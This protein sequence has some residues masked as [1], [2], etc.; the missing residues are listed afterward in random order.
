VIRYQ[1]DMQEHWMKEHHSINP[2][3]DRMTVERLHPLWTG[4]NRKTEFNWHTTL[5]GRK[6]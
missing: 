1:D 6:Q 3:L 2:H 5:E 4:S